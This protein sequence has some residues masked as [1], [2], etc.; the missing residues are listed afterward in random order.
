MREIR[1]QQNIS[2]FDITLDDA[3]RTKIINSMNS[4]LKQL[5]RYEIFSNSPFLNKDYVYL[6]LIQNTIRYFQKCKHTPQNELFIRRPRLVEALYYVWILRFIH[7][8]QLIDAIRDLKEAKNEVSKVY[9]WFLTLKVYIK[10]EEDA[11]AA[12]KKQKEIEALERAK[13]MK[14]DEHP[15]HQTEATH[16]A[17][18]GGKLKNLLNV[19]KQPSPRKNVNSSL[20][21]KVVN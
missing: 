6:Q 12:L 5:K 9:R 7:E 20:A 8:F 13:N 21:K 4:Y 19:R 1:E 15:I 16:A 14:I 10:P 3:M 18:A 2:E 11:L 17:K